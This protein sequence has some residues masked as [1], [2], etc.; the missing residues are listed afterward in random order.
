MWQLTHSQAYGGLL[1]FK[2][3]RYVPADIEKEVY[4]PLA[5]EAYRI[6]NGYRE[7]PR[8]ICARICPELPGPLA[9]GQ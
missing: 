6:V 2:T 5:E 3:G 4:V 7:D 9:I 1:A 8:I